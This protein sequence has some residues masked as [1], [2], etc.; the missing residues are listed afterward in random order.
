MSL[1][2]QIS[3]PITYSEKIT[4]SKINPMSV[5]KHTWSN[6]SSISKSEF[7]LFLDMWQVV[8]TISY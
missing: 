1:I 6:I 4:D 5:I 3:K 8:L 7:S 2:L